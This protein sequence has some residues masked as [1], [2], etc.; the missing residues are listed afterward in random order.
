[1]FK[2]FVIFIKFYKNKKSINIYYLQKIILKLVI[3]IKN[4]KKNLIV[5]NSIYVYK[6]LNKMN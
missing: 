5:H 4:N 3:Y 6:I 1:M 2:T